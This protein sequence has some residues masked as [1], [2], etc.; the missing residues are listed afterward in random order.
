MGSM[1]LRHLESALEDVDAFDPEHQDV[2]LEQYPTSPHLAANLIHTAAETYGDIEGRSVVDYGCGCAMLSIAAAIMGA[3]TVTG[4]DIDPNALAVAQE[5][6][7]GMELEEVIDF[8]NC[9]ME[10]LSPARHHKLADTVVMNPPFGTRRPGID[11][12]FLQRGIQMATTAVYSLHKTS[13]RE[14]ILKTVAEWG[15][16]GEVIAELK[17]DIPAM[18]KFH[19]KKSKER[20]HQ[21]SPAKAKVAEVARAR[22]VPRNDDDGKNSFGMYRYSVI[23]FS[24]YKIMK[25]AFAPR[26]TYN[27]DKLH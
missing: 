20:S 26:R 3:S 13:T 16:K 4:F 17:F 18:Y 14:H 23:C 6:V 5:N 21:T 25:H 1:K 22:V 10:E 11:M 19:T 24:V 9:N 27:S 2:M 7:E 8:V 12:V 15:V